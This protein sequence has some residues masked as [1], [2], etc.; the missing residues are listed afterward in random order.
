M[1]KYYDLRL[2]NSFGNCF[3]NQCIPTENDIISRF[4]PDK[5]QEELQKISAYQL[6]AYKQK[7][8]VKYQKF[9][10]TH[11]ITVQSIEED[12]SNIIQSKLNVNSYFCQYQYENNNFYIYCTSDTIALITNI[13]KEISQNIIVSH[14]PYRSLFIADNEEVMDLSFLNEFYLQKVIVYKCKNAKLDQQL[15]LDVL[16]LSD[17]NHNKLSFKNQTQLKQ[18]YLPRNKIVSADALKSLSGLVSLNLNE[19]RI[20]SLL[21]I[22]NLQCLTQLKMNENRICDLSPLSNLV[23]LQILHLQ[24]NRIQNL[25]G[26]QNLVNLKVLY[27]KS[28]QI[29]DLEPLRKLVN[30][31]LLFMG[32][33]QIENIQPLH[34]LVKI[35]NLYLRTNRIK[36]IHA[37]INMTE[38]IE[39]GLWDNQIEDIQVLENMKK[40]EDLTIHRNLIQDIQSLTGLISLK[41]L[42]IQYNQ[43]KNVKPIAH[44]PNF[45]KYLT[46]NQQ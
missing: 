5:L 30:L 1:N 29:K 31:K 20:G 35:T 24:Q 12:I 46:E 44:H 43:I 39:L 2:I 45:K 38:L 36:N 37:L 3:T 33:N 26:L 23:G 21:F 17:S 28:N 8:I 22:A 14:I 32:D 15:N 4:G 27:L 40:L 16:Y 41:Q 13:V 7:M 9:I 11:Q 19:N 42:D 25:N 18:L 34:G 6:D 10:R